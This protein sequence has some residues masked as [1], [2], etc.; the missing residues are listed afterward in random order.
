MENDINKIPTVKDVAE[1]AGVSLS[2]VSRYINGYNLREEKSVLIK[3]AIEKLGYKENIMAK[4]VRSGRSM[5]VGVLVSGYKETFQTSVLSP[6]EIILENNNYAVLVSDYGGCNKRLLAKLEFFK[7][8]MVDGIVMFSYEFDE[9]TINKINEIVAYGIP[10]IIIDEDIHGLNVDKILADNINVSF[11]AVEYLIH[12]NHTKIGIIAGHHKHNVSIERIE[13]YKECLRAYKIDLEDQYIKYGEYSKQVSYNITKELLSMKSPPTAIFATS[14]HISYGAL[15]AI[16]DLNLKIPQDISIIGYDYD[17][18]I[19]TLVPVL[20][21]IEQPTER[22]GEVAANLLL[23]RIR[24]NKEDFPKTIR[25]PSR[26]I[27]K[28]SVK[29]L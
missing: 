15:M 2:T 14:S 29:Q 24:G 22:M 21:S 7:D 13:G 11:R 5:T 4:G 8:R 3:H 25:I 18:T 10:V 28:E 26:L 9:E 6:L 12:A 20:T 27:V 1:L 17:D 23:D 16:H 19:D